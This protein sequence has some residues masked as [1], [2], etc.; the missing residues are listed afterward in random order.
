MSAHK[1]KTSRRAF[2]VKGGAALGAGV[3]GSAM[4]RESLHGDATSSA[5]ELEQI[6]QVH[7]AYT[8]RMEA[9][10]FEAAAELFIEQAQLNLDGNAVEGITAIRQLLSDRYRHQV[11]DAQHSAYRPNGQ[12]A[13]DSLTVSDDLRSARATWHVDVRVCS[14]L[15]GDCTAAQMA[16]LQGMVGDVRWEAGLI[17]ASYV[18][19]GG[20]WRIEALRY[21]AS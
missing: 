6:R 8:G 1:V 18:K 11:A 10:A 15:Q 7:L 17:E 20:Q 12:Q 5:A 13:D 19:T 4:G 21:R 14:P 9:Q 3:A 16:R 2:F